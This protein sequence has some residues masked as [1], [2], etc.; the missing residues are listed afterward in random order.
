MAHPCG[1]Y[2]GAELN[3]LPLL[4]LFIIFFATD[5][6]TFGDSMAGG[7]RESKLNPNRGLFASKF[8]K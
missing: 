7:E 2:F 5:A 8:L 4:L 3:S 6:G 1:A